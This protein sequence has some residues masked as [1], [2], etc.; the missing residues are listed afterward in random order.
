MRRTFVLGLLCA[1]V[2]AVV[3]SSAQQPRVRVYSTHESS[4]TVELRRADA[5]VQAMLASGTIRVRE[6]ERDP[7]LPQREHERLQQHVR[8]IPIWGGDVTRQSESGVPISIFGRIF[9]DVRVETSPAFDA[10]D[11]RAAIEKLA[12]VQTGYTPELVILPMPE[13]GFRLTWSLAVL[14]AQLRVVRYFLDARTGALAWSLDETTTQE[15]AVGRGRGTLADEKKISTENVAG[16]YRTQDRLR[17]L[18]VQTYD[19][20]GNLEET[21]SLLNRRRPFVPA[22]LAADSDN[23]WED[24]PVVDAHVYTAWTY[25][26]YH[27]RFNRFGLNGN[28]RSVISVV[29]PVRRED[30]LQASPDVVGL[31][32][33]NA[34]YLHPDVM[35][36]G[37]G[38]PDNFV[39]LPFRQ[40]VNF[41]SA[42]L[43]IVA[44]E[45]THGVIRYSSNL[46][47]R[48]ESGALNEGFADIMGV[49]AEFFF[50]PPGDGL[51]RADYLQGEDVF[52]PGAARS[53]ENPSA[54]GD[55]DHYSRRFTGP[56]DNG[57]VHTNSLIA[58]HA[59]YLAIE[60]GAN[61][62]SGFAVQGVGGA[63]REQIERTFYRAFVLMLPSTA[64][65]ATARAATIQAARDLYGSGS[66]VERAVTQA[67]NAVGVN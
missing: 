55:P 35:V 42:A 52:T 12:G 18:F 9:E 2:M 51:M 3:P 65:F 28:N 40:R 32:Y 54:F 43:D 11:A 39:I 53:L 47:N 24:G 33:L 23:T 4:P 15:P 26:F 30:L 19:M 5:D 27:K 44:H 20:R 31:F 17:P 29:H 41:F 56:E 60:G 1:T 7:L 8:G 14:N 13:G 34:F 59:F 10:A 49:S 36:Y 64:T 63:N 37:V 38:L 57:G 22:D 46:Q 45:L 21:L 61:R 16:A 58:S 6:R 62:T 50:Q 67:W 66:E 25:D 48:G